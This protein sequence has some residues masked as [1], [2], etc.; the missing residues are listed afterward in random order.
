MHQPGMGSL[1]AA[2]ALFALS[3]HGCTDGTVDAGQSCVDGD[4]DACVSDPGACTN[5]AENP[6]ICD[7]FGWDPGP[8]PDP[9][10]DAIDGRG[11][12]DQTGGAH[13]CLWQDDA[14]AAISFTVDDNC[15]P[16]HNWWVTQAEAYGFK[17]TWFV[18]TGNIGTGAYWG[19]WADFAALAARGHEIQSHTVTH[20]DN[21]SEADWEY[22]QSQTDIETNIPG[23]RCRTLAYPNGT[24]YP[25]IASPYFIGARGVTG[26]LN[27]GHDIDFMNTR[28][29]SSFYY[30][31]THWASITN[32]FTFD[33]GQASSYRAWQ[34][35]HF[36]D[37]SDVAKA[38]LITGFELIRA[39]GRD[40]WVGLFREV[41]QYARE[42]NDAT[43]EV[44][45]IAASRIQLNVTDTLDDDLYDYPLTI[46]VRLDGS[47]TGA[48]ASQGGTPAPVELIAHEGETYAL[49]NVIPDRGPVTLSRVP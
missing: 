46:K 38:D 18:I 16:D 48:T 11:W 19:A 33:A 42:R 26:A 30:A 2:V 27:H 47:W 32:M 1:C 6:P 4:E 29:L 3:L 12:P 39:Q 23:S 10:Y 41:I 22:R 14:L 8:Y 21:Q 36:H 45:G 35:M 34:A 37:L 20:S 17:V 9:T 7:F 15:A 49:V 28:S 25:T 13:L 31:T 40:A 43:V 5:G 44:Q 24:A